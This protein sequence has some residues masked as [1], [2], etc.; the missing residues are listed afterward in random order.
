M[1]R[2]ARC[3]DV[4]IFGKENDVVSSGRN[5]DHFVLELEA[6]WR[7]GDLF[8]LEAENTV[9]VLSREA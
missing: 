9:S 8:L 1:L 2:V 3:V 4:S 7:F 5:L 6:Y